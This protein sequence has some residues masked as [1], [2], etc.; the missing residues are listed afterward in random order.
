MLVELGDAEVALELLD[1]LRAERPDDQD[2]IEGR[3]WVLDR[4]GRS[5]DAKAEFR[6][7]VALN[8]GRSDRRLR[9][10]IRR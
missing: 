6:R 4:L 9:T 2:V 7:Y 8:Q 3:A 10:R 5:E 1:G